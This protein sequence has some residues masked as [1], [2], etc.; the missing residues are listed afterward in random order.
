MKPSDLA[1]LS[2]AARARLLARIVVSL[3]DRLGGEV[4]IPMADL[5]RGG[6]VG[7]ALEDGVLLVA[8]GDRERLREEDTDAR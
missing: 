1:H 8:V 7:F 6:Q 4:R 5:E 3:A 2:N